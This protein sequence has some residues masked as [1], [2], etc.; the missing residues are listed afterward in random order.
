M[1]LMETRREIDDWL[2]GVPSCGFSG[3][4]GPLGPFATTL[5]YVSLG[6][7]NWNGGTGREDFE[8]ASGAA[9]PD[10][11][12]V[13]SGGGAEVVGDVGLAGDAE[14]AGLAGGAEAVGL[15]EGA[16][17]PGGAGLPPESI[18][19]VRGGGKGFDG[20]PPSSRAE[21]WRASIRT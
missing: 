4:V 17:L 14:S 18:V 19:A 13:G 9:T 11:F 3:F 12:G 20:I 8:A 1:L 10:A 21:S 7:P 6:W 5:G 2:N 16:E 15:A